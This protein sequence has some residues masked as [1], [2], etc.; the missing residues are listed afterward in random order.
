MHT[1]S[2]A[3]HVAH[4][5]PMTGFGVLVRPALG[6]D[7]R[8]PFTDYTLIDDVPTMCF[9]QSVQQTDWDSMI[10][11]LDRLG[12]EPVEDDEVDGV[13][14]CVGVTATGCEVVALYGREPILADPCLGQI[15]TAE[16]ELRALAGL[17]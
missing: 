4:L 16:A 12:W 14:L 3:T 6:D 10:R 15:M 1:I 11:Q 9:G 2:T 7:L 8:S 13:P 17:A 5:D